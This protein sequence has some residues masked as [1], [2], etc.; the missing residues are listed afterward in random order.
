MPQYRTRHNTNMWYKKKIFLP[1][2]G[3]QTRVYSHQINEMRGYL[4]DTIW[5][6]FPCPY[7]IELDFIYKKV[8]DK[9]WF[10]HTGCGQKALAH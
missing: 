5:P 2:V 7:W 1:L 9:F 6:A 4:V 10:C 8:R 3:R